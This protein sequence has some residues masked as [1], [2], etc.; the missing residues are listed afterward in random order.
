MTKLHYPSPSRLIE[1]PNEVL[2][3]ICSSAEDRDLPSLRL[4]CRELCDTATP[5]FAKVN[6]TERFHV[7]SP[8]SIDTLVKITEHPVFGGYVRTVAICSARRTMNSKRLYINAYVKTGRFARRLERIFNNIRSRHGFVNISIYDYPGRS[9]F[10]GYASPV[11][12]RC[13]GWAQLSQATLI[14]HRT[15]ETLEQTIYAARHARCPVRY[16]KIHLF[17][18]RSSSLIMHEELDTAMCKVLESNLTPLS[19]DLGGE[20][21]SKCPTIITH[22]P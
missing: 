8:Y 6:F 14:A 9:A 10:L 16:P 2:M 7:V 19:I 4:T 11:Q 20:N 15:A 13:F 3:E 12:M 21:N 1:L 22:S 18:Y 5:H 17:A